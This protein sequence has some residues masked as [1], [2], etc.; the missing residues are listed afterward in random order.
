MEQKLK[1]T[2]TWITEHNY[3]LAV[4][5]A[6]CFIALTLSVGH[7]SNET[8]PGNLDHNARYLSEP[9]THLDYMAEWDGVHYIHI[10]QHGY[11]DD[12]LTAFFPLYPLA[13]RALMFAVPS[14]LISALL[15][16]WAC[17]AGALW[18]YLKILKEFLNQDHIGALQGLMLF[19]FFPTGVFLAATYSESMLAFFG[20]GALYFAI[21]GRYLG[22]GIMSALATA[23][24]PDGVFI[25]VLVA[26]LLREAKAK[27]WQIMLSGAMGLIGIAGYAIYLWAKIGKPLDF[28]NAQKH[29]IKW[30]SSQFLT[31][32]FHSTTPVA[33]ILFALA[34]WAVIYWWHKRTSFALF[35]LLFALLPLLTGNFAGYPRYLLIDFP[36]QIM[37]LNK[38][39]RSTLGYAVV[40]LLSA[41]GWAYFTMHYV[42]GYTGGS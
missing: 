40:L 33:L 5:V 42:A 39:K 17:L 7:Y 14:P 26:L 38:F 37:L 11:T 35:G 22:A 19:L 21:K 29:H 41:L 12:S 3:L 15:V 23:S 20:L 10:A 25:L 4:L 2:L 24:R 31:A 9:G 16:S 30:M 18:F 28:I 32:F 27:L 36:L 8:I 1:N 6:V 34:V 13:I